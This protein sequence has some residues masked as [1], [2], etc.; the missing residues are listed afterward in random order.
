MEHAP[1]GTRASGTIAARTSATAP[2][3]SRGVVFAFLAGCALVGALLAV[4]GAL[5]WREPAPSDHRL[6]VARPSFA[7]ASTDR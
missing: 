7:D 2:G 6:P 1:L 3:T 4:I 5:A